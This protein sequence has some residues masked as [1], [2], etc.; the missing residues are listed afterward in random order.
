[1]VLDSIDNDKQEVK[2]FKQTSDDPY[3]RHHYKLVYDDGREV[4]FDNYEDA[5]V[6]WFQHAGKFLSHIEVLDI[7]EKSR[8]FK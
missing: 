7:K 1:L 6:T 4:V 2:V 8:G 5:Q 3:I